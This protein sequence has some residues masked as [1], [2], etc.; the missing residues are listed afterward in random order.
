M[1][2]SRVE[3]TGHNISYENSFTAIKRDIQKE[4]LDKP[5]T[6]KKATMEFEPIEERPPL[7]AT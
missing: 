4:T 2:N 3:Q 5:G 7:N 6:K 1:E